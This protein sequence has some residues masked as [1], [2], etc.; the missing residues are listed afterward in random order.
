MRVYVGVSERVVVGVSAKGHGGRELVAEV[1]DK[2]ISDECEDCGTQWAT[3][4]N[5]SSDSE[6]RVDDPLELDVVEV[7]PVELLDGV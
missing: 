4:P 2:G 1:A 5:T 6:A 7:I 3:L